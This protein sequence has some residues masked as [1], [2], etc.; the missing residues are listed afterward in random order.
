MPSQRSQ[1]YEPS[2]S[3]FDR[4][5]RRAKVGHTVN[6]PKLAWVD[7][8]QTG[9]FE[10]LAEHEKLTA[11]GDSN[12]YWPFRDSAE[13]KK[14]VA[15]DLQRE[16]S[17]A[18]L[19]KLID[20]GRL[21]VLALTPGGSTLLGS[22]RELTLVCRN[23]GDTPA[24]DVECEVEGRSPQAFAS[25]LQRDAPFNVKVLF[26]EP[27]AGTASRTTV[28]LRYTTQYG[29][30]IDERH[31]IELEIGGKARMSQGRRMRLLADPFEID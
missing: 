4:V 16:S 28:A 10:L 20:Q 14:R 9:I 25:P 12:W 17:R 23:V 22:Q 24:L 15:F 8:R 11:G 26:D 19:A 7:D 31:S 3:L 21:P 13:L 1:Q 6:T 18:R 29:H 5:F 27:S 30:R 2:G